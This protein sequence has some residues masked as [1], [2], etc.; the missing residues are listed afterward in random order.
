MSLSEWFTALCYWLVGATGTTTPTTANSEDDVGSAVGDDNGGILAQLRKA[1]VIYGI[2]INPLPQELEARYTGESAYSLSSKYWSGFDTV[3]QKVLVLTGGSSSI[4]CAIVERMADGTLSSFAIQELLF[5]EGIK[6]KNIREFIQTK[7]LPLKSKY[8]WDFVILTAGF[9]LGINKGK[10]TW[11]KAF[12]KQT[13]FV[14]S[15]H[16][17]E[18]CTIKAAP[19]LTFHQDDGSVAFQMR[20][21]IIREITVNGEVRKP[22]FTNN[23]VGDLGGASAY[24][25]PEGGPGV[26]INFTKGC[27]GE[28]AEALIELN[29]QTGVKDYFCTGVWR[30]S[31]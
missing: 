12:K 28:A 15:E 22:T 3:G 14:I 31:A 7:V 2:T 21:L 30:D 10:N 19:I 5:K 18:Q 8:N 9:Y 1:V 29:G 23:T 20:G 11:E 4:Q 25:R 6:G 17:V 26:N 13:G 24:A 16:P 27:V